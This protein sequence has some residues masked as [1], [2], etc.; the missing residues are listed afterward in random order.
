MQARWGGRITALANL[1][2]DPRLVVHLKRDAHVDLPA[3]ASLVDDDATRRRVLQ[4]LSASWYRDQEPL[5]DLVAT[6][7]M[8]EVTFDAPK[9]PG[10]YDFVCSFPGH[11][12]AGMRGVLVVK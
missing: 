11:Y 7:P 1:A 3:R 4:H 6:A 9:A 12:L 10:K 2:A 5:D 8:V